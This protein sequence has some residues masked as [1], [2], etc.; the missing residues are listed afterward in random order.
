MEYDIAKG[1]IAAPIVLITAPWVCAVEGAHE[2]DLWQENT[3][4]CFLGFGKGL[5]RGV[6]GAPAVVL[7]GSIYGVNQF[8]TGVADAKNDRAGEGSTIAENFNHV[9]DSAFLDL[10]LNSAPES[11][12]NQGEGAPVYQFWITSEVYKNTHTCPYTYTKKNKNSLVSSC[13]VSRSSEHACN[14]TLNKTLTHT[15]T[16]TH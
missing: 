3:A 16:H 5:A 13:A 14:L 15:H 4:N 10:C 8:R 2:G 12:K 9:T 11:L 1:A 7:S 6:L